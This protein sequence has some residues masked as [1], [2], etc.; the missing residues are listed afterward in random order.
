MVDVVSLDPDALE[1][2]LERHRANPHFPMEMSLADNLVEV[3]RKANEFVPS[4]A[5]SIL[6][7]NPREKRRD[8][9]QNTLTFLAAF[10]DKS[11]ALVGRTIPSR[12]GIAGRVYQSGAAYFTTDADEDP[13]FDDTTDEATSFR[14]RSLVAIPI[15]IGKEVCGVLELLNRKGAPG[16]SSQ[17]RELLEIF[18]GYISV[19][20]QN[21]L[22]GRLAQEFAKR[23]NLT[24]L[25][26]DRYLH[27]AVSQAIEIARGA[28]KNLA[29]LF[30][31][32][33]FFKHVNDCHG[34]LTGSQVLRE[35]GHLLQRCITGPGAIVAR[36]GGDEFVIAVPGADLRQGTQLAERLRTEIAATVFCARPGDIQPDPKSISEL[37]CSIGV[38]TLDHL[39]ADLGT[40][41]IKSGLLRLSDVA[42]YHA[43]ASGRNRVAIADGLQVASTGPTRSG[44]R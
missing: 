19:A 3:L 6:L 39:P 7:D 11:R 23:D 21:V 15:R 34:H 44:F 20:I 12:Q 17:D 30:L 27:P 40:P 9:R 16:Y 24:G 4:E 22:D 43:K 26:N 10:G 8:R 32:L 37:T 13:F 25:Y 36:Y 33:D 29:L 41:E 28:R 5:G 42:M 1:L 38:A 31:D 2:F 14:T 18:A 35:V